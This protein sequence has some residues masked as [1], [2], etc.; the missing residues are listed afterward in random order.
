M[1]SPT[2]G[3]ASSSSRC[4]ATGPRATRRGPRGRCSRSAPM[5]SARAS[6]TSRCCTSPRRRRRSRG[7]RGS[8]ARSSSTCSTTCTTG[9]RCWTLANK[10]WT[11][12]PLPGV[13]A[14][15]LNTRSAWAVD[16]MA[17]PT[18]TGWTRRGFVEPIDARAR[19]ARQARRR[20]SRRA[21]R[22]STRA[23]SSSSSTSRRRRTAPRSR[24]S[25]SARDHLA[26]DGSHPTLLYGY[27]GFEISLHARA[28]IRSRAAAWQERGGVYVLAN[29][30]GGGGVRAGVAPGGDPAPPPE[31][32]TTTSSRSPRISIARKVTSTPHLGIQGGSNGGLLIGRDAHRSG[33]ICSA[34]SYARRRCST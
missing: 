30:R 29:I 21:P 34:P 10:K 25:R 16:P 23:A 17:R 24:T 26:L 31:A 12:K 28:T 27:G 19:H 13:S 4:A 14:N 18:T 6:A 22:S 11:Q 5:T 7:R 3:T 15:D 33:R 1:R 9:S 2:S 20:L 8:R 32:R